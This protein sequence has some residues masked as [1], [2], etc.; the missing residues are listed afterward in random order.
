MHAGYT[1]H[2][3][4]VRRHN[5]QDQVVYDVGDGKELTLRQ[6]SERDDLQLPLFCESTGANDV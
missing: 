3:S 2:N 4:T 5:R 1:I 6:I